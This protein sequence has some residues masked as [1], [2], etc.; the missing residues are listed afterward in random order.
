MLQLV[1]S[2]TIVVSIVV[3]SLLDNFSIR[4]CDCDKRYQSYLA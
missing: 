3:V 2:F 4:H 1:M